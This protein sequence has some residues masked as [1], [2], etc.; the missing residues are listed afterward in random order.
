MLTCKLVYP[1]AILSTDMPTLTSANSDSVTVGS[2]DLSNEIALAYRP[3]A[4][5]G[6]HIT[7]VHPSDD[8]IASPGFN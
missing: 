1:F 2:A 4:I 8:S 3:P 6:L 7:V 5:P